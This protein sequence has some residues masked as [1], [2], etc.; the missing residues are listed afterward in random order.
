MEG[1]GSPRRYY[2]IYLQVSKSTRFV[3]GGEK[4]NRKKSQCQSTT[5]GKC[6][7]E[8]LVKELDKNDNYWV[9]SQCGRYRKFA[10][11]K[12]EFFMSVSSVLLKVTQQD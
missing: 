11:V 7:R 9:S 3:V 6:K 2:Y 1:A 12:F 4:N 10:R 5:R 8:K